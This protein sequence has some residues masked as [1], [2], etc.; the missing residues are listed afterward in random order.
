MCNKYVEIFLHCTRDRQLVTVC[1]RL[2]CVQITIIMNTNIL[3][4]Y[5]KRCRRMQILLVNYAYIFSHGK[6]HYGL[7]HVR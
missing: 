1:L 6:Q 5:M 7:I 2:I 4:S 3:I